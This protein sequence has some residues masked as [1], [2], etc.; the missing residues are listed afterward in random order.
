MHLAHLQSELQRSESLFEADYLRVK[1]ICCIP[2]KGD[3]K[4]DVLQISKAL[5]DLR[6]M[7]EASAR[8]NSISLRH[9]T[10]SVAA[11]P[12]ARIDNEDDFI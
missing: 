4:E 9:I 12:M 11:A 10:R 6:R 3:A 5:Q 2:L 7:S 8:T 1:E